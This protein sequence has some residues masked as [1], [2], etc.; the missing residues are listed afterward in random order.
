MITE[1]TE[2]LP[3]AAWPRICSLTSFFAQ[4]QPVSKCFGAHNGACNANAV[5]RSAVKI[6]FMAHWRFD[7]ERHL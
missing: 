6:T 7:V 3:F 5:T 4:T 2:A 1:R